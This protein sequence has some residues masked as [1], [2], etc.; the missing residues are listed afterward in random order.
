MITF[1]YRFGKYHFIR[2]YCTDTVLVFNIQLHNFTV[3]ITKVYSNNV[4]QQ[5]PYLLIYYIKAVYCHEI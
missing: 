2:I 5:R 4:E 3:K 1:N